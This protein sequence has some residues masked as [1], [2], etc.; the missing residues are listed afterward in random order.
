[1]KPLKLRRLKVKSRKSFPY[2]L[3]EA[4]PVCLYCVANRGHTLRAS[5]LKP[6]NMSRQ[7]ELDCFPH[8]LWAVPFSQQW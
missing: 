4:V 8:G 2:L 3:S 1:M 7:N 6:E 5:F